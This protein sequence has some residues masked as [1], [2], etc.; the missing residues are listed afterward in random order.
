MTA[1]TPAVLYC[2]STGTSTPTRLTGITYPNGRVLT[3]GYNSGADAAVG[4][5]SY[6]ADSDGTQL[7]DYYYLGLGQI[8]DVSNRRSRASTSISAR[9]TAAAN[10][11][12]RSVQPRHGHGFRGDRAANL[13]EIK[14]GYDVSGN[15]LWQ[16]QPTAASNGVALDE[17]YGYN[18]LNELTGATQGTLN[19]AHTAITANQDLTETW[20]PGRHGQLVEL[21]AD[22]R[23]DEPIDQ[24]R[25]TN[26]LNRNHRATT[27]L[28]PGP[29]PATT[30]PAT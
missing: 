9:R 7:A 14:Y 2:Y 24:D 23:H 25:Q 18:A 11:M 22:R 8:D 1:S 10:W 28:Q 17:L 15:E 4:R 26:A 21:H 6:L 13:D 12:R 30:P 29:C 16:A 27:A 5:V 20:T 19:S 3:Y